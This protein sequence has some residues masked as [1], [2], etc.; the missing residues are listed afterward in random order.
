MASL[1]SSRFGLCNLNEGRITTI[2]MA[3]KSFNHTLGSLPTTI[4]EKMSQLAAL[5]KTVN[6]GQGFPDAELQGPQSMKEVVCENILSSPNQYPPL[7][8][9]A[10]LRKALATHSAKYS[11]IVMS[12]NDVV[13]T[14]GATEALASAFLGLLNPGDEVICF[15]PIYDSY[16]P[17][18]KIVGAHPRIISLKPPL[19]TFDVEDLKQAFNKNTKLIVI[20]TPHNPTGKVFG[21]DE[22]SI[23]GKLCIKYGTIAVLDEVYEHLVY[24][25]ISKHRSLA[26]VSGMESMCI[27]IGSAGKTFSF[28]D[29][30]VGWAL[31]PKVL[32]DAVIKAHQ[33][34]TFTV[35]SSLQ[36]G[37][38]HGLQQC[39]EFYLNLGTVLYKKRMKL[40][41]K[42]EDIGF[43]VLP[44]QGTYFLIADF[45]SF[46]QDENEDDVAFSLRLTVEAGVTVI[47]VSAF[48]EDKSSA[49]KTLV[50]FV[51]CKTDAK[52]DEACRLLAKYLHKT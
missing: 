21:E 40:Q 42:L 43:I 45:S 51:F 38:A 50:R 8:G 28:T 19:W 35:N 30:K 32:I 7:T 23:I 29:W 41:A 11:G 12:E 17:L 37:V 3:C 26:S 25:D 39:S 52:L 31:G 13:V 36:L 34:V 48:Y 18:I 47:P 15:Q 6:L 20:N 49:P 33:F 5:H 14:V 9:V 22:L 4:F 24:A 1:N 46:K 16:I 44:A 2:A 27:R 10:S